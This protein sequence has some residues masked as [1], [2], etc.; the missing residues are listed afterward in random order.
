MFS[1]RHTLVRHNETSA[2]GRSREEEIKRKRKGLGYILGFSFFYIRFYAAEEE[3]T[4]RL[5][6]I[7][8]FRN[9]D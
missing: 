4:Q 1:P 2:V 9:M 3:S 7:S 6:S 8:P 5:K